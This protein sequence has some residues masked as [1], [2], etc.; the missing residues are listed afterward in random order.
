[1]LKTAARL[2]TAVLAL[3]LVAGTPQMADA[4]KTV[5][6]KAELTVDCSNCM[7]D[8][9]TRYSILPDTSAGYLPGNGVISEVLNNNSVYTLDTL[10]TLDNG[11]VGAGSRYAELVFFSPVE[12]QFPGHRLPECWF[13]DYSQMQAVNWSVFASNSQSFVKMTVGQQYPGFS[14]TDF[15]VRNRFCPNQVFRFYLRH[16]NACIVRTTSTT[17]EV[18]SGPCGAMVNFGE[19]N[20]QGQ[21][22][23]AG[24]TEDYGDWRLPYKLKLTSQ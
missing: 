11:L 24:Q 15:N 19:A 12:N 21:G 18:T 2:A 23:Q 22:G 4:G 3:A 8:T 7:T 10:D 1:M 20:L 17:W 6:M 9:P 5:P 13:G 16:Y 14:R